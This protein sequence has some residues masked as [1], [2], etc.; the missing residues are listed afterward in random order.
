MKS[1]KIDKII[2]L[3]SYNP[4]SE[5]F[6]QHGILRFK[7][8]MLVKA[9]ACLLIF[10]FTINTVAYGYDKEIFDKLR[11]IRRLET[12]DKTEVEDVLATATS[13]ASEQKPK[14]TRE[15]K[16]ELLTIAQ[17]AIKSGI[18]K[19]LEGLELALTPREKAYLY[20]NIRPATFWNVV[21]AGFMAAQ[22]DVFKL[23]GIILLLWTTPL[24]MAITI[25]LWWTSSWYGFIIAL[26][27]ST[28]APML[29]M[30][31]A[32]LLST[33]DH[34]RLYRLCFREDSM[35]F[36]NPYTSTVLVNV[37]GYAHVDVL[38]HAH[39]SDI[40]PS[41]GFELSVKG[42]TMHETMHLLKALKY[43]QNDEIFATVVANF[44]I[45]Q[46]AP[47]K[48]NDF[49]NRVNRHTLNKL[50]SMDED[51]M[52]DT[53]KT[54]FVPDHLSKG[55]TVAE[56]ENM[57]GRTIGSYIAL[58]LVC[59]DGYRDN[60]DRQWEFIRHHCLVVPP[61]QDNAPT[62]DQSASST[63]Q[64]DPAQ[65]DVNTS[66]S[67]AQAGGITRRS[68]LMGMV[69]A[70]GTAA[71]GRTKVIGAEAE[72]EN[73]T[74]LEE[75][76]RLSLNIR[77]NRKALL[78]K[79]LLLMRRDTPM[80]LRAFAEIVDKRF[81]QSRSKVPLR[82]DWPE[83]VDK[84]SDEIGNKEDIRRSVI[85]LIQSFDI[86]AKD[87]AWVLTA[88]SRIKLTTPLIDAMALRLKD[89]KGETRDRL[90]MIILNSYKPDPDHFG[91]P[92]TLMLINDI[93]REVAIGVL[94][95]ADKA[96]LH[97]TEDEY[98]AIKARI[99]KQLTYRGSKGGITQDS[100]FNIYG[101][102]GMQQLRYELAHEIGHNVLDLRGIKYNTLDEKILHEFFAYLTSAGC[103]GYWG[104][105]A[106]SMDQH[107]IAGYQVTAIE[108][109][110]KK[111]GIKADWKKISQIALKMIPEGKSLEDVVTA[112]FH[113][114]GYKGEI[115][116]KRLKKEHKRDIYVPTEDIPDKDAA[117]PIEE[118]VGAAAIATST[119]TSNIFDDIP[120]KQPTLDEINEFLG[121]DIKPGTLSA[122]QAMELVARTTKPIV[123]FRVDSDSCISMLDG[124]IPA[125]TQELKM[126]PIEQ[127]G[128]FS[129]AFYTSRSGDSHEERLEWSQGVLREYLEAND[130]N[131]V[132]KEDSIVG[133]ARTKKRDPF[134]STTKSIADVR[135]RLKTY[136]RGDQAVFLIEIPAG[137]LVIDAVRFAKGEQ[138]VL[139]PHQIPCTW[140][141][142]VFYTSELPFAPNLERE[143]LLAEWPSSW[144]DQ[145]MLLEDTGIGKEKG[146]NLD[147][148]NMRKGWLDLPWAWLTIV[149]HKRKNE[150][151]YPINADIP[152]GN[153]LK[154]QPAAFALLMRNPQNHSLS[155]NN[156]A[157]G[158]TDE[159]IIS[160][161]DR[162]KIEIPA[163]STSTATARSELSEE[164]YAGSEIPV[165]LASS[166]QG[167]ANR[168]DR[169]VAA[170][171]LIQ[172]DIDM[173][174]KLLDGE[175]IDP[176]F[177]NGIHLRVEL[178][179]DRLPVDPKERKKIEQAA[180][181]W[182]DSVKSRASNFDGQVVRNG[183][184]GD[185]LIKITAS[186]DRR[187]DDVIGE[188]ISDT[189]VDINDLP[190]FT[191]FL[192]I[193]FAGS[194][195][196]LD[197]EEY[198]SS[199]Y[200]YSRLV[201]YIDDC[202]YSLT[203]TR[204]IAQE[205]NNTKDIL[206]QKKLIED[207]L[208]YIFIDLPP[209]QKIRYDKNMMKELLAAV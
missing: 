66:T 35:A 97:L 145:K 85:G 146:I 84:V 129:S 128:I 208:R 136:D 88:L 60:P 130:F 189:D 68:A 155:L 48:M 54:K 174:T 205:Y 4:P 142:R 2:S 199:P 135:N 153:A 141:N 204:Y 27:L 62:P 198:A 193:A 59:K 1:E 154:N 63:S 144:E 64:D 47:Y 33:I 104:Q 30:L 80:G 186:R 46:Q 178:N 21:R 69:G 83:L 89:T 32:F 49:K 111:R 39:H 51:Q 43:V 124:F 179:Q 122:E 17:D 15:R 202:Y 194:L 182:L 160:E 161:G 197:Y 190:Q 98:K 132:V 126:K 183:T 131:H 82:F 120:Y 139:I 86:N 16:K 3:I 180:N 170:K 147:S 90:L 110:L 76:H 11:N 113:E 58:Y 105:V 6:R 149:N 163:T 150:F 176:Q 57:Y 143:G 127:R 102:S 187:G 41:A 125:T 164:A 167:L 45:L 119:S 173:L 96:F 103:A 42:T 12:M 24:L 123:V 71:L 151:G 70:M 44:A 184:G 28:S 34:T 188:C 165:L 36:H 195:I 207:K 201:D 169:V 87:Q 112:I 100:G 40:I 157:I 61:T 10:T 185:K 171:A 9:V 65:P 23:H 177:F 181:L 38:G 107:L 162:I 172:K 25:P 191:G 50:L 22:K 55:S 134:I 114:S 152:L 148:S 81:E 7:Q 101:V 121:T 158:L 91:V 52:L 20:R 56:K 75:I 19:T 29:T 108:E 203:G 206:K 67:S 92:L 37:M 156:E 99:E 166:K 140:I 175:Y 118:G 116:A 73:K 53:L 95:E 13:T 77:A 72:G 209:A 200:E 94:K 78:E 168:N 159:A 18:D 106:V 74:L 117:T 115:K 192:N 196:P 138:I 5:D 93:L 14:M 31:I 109:E 137:S 26:T 8:S 133:L 79:T